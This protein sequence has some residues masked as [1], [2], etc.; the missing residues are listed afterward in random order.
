MH[1][2]IRCTAKCGHS[3]VKWSKYMKREIC[4]Y[5]QRFRQTKWH[6]LYALYIQSD[7]RSVKQERIFVDPCYLLRIPHWTG[8]SGWDLWNMEIS[9]RQCCFRGR[10]SLGKPISPHSWWWCSFHSTERDVIW[11]V[12]T[13]LSSR[14]QQGCMEIED[15]LDSA[16]SGILMEPVE[17]EMVEIFD[18]KMCVRRRTQPREMEWVHI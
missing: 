15:M 17:I 5:L 1:H 3:I 12:N 11:F 14:R 6:M 2:L 4:L 13:E 7:C 16:T 8:E 18:A 9:W 10:N